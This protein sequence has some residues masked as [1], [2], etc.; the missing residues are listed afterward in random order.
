[1]ECFFFD[2]NSHCSRKKKNQVKEMHITSAV[3]LK[4]EDLFSPRR[5]CPKN[6]TK[7]DETKKYWN[8]F[9]IVVGQIFT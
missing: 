1:M 2:K 9:L 3:N 8:L 4:N 6:K 5:F 7:N